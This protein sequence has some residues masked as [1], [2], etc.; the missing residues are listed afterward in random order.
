MTVTYRPSHFSMDSAADAES[1]EKLTSSNPNLLVSD[2]IR[3]QLEDLVKIQSPSRTFD[4]HQ[5]NESIDQILAGRSENEYGC[6]IHYPW[7]NRLVHLLP[8]KEFSLVRTNRNRN[9]IKSEEQEQLSKKKIGLIGLSVGHAVATT[10][11]L[12]RSFGELIIADFDS[13]DLSNLN[14]IRSSTFNIDVPKTIITAREIAE[15]DPYLKVSCYHEGITEENMTEFLTGLDILIDECDSIDVK[16]KIRESAR[17]MQIPVIMETSD[18]GML[19]VERFDQ[20]NS[21]PI[22]HGLTNGLDARSLNGLSNKEKIPHVL[23]IIGFEAAS[24]KL[25]NSMSKI[26]KSLS[27]WP[28]LGSDVMHGGGA[29]AQVARRI[30]LGENIISGRYYVDLSELIPVQND[31]VT[32]KKSRH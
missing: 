14:R 4:E 16:L 15:L 7:S 24:T 1:L 8:E 29:V 30:L 9:K 12:E 17:E 10:L 27:T 32:A 22:L 11:A 20:N 23:N 26:G 5:L 3:S 31:T 28:Q 18:R 25:K 2:S 13:L 6:W 21:Y 19:D